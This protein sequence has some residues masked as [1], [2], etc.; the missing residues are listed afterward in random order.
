LTA[1]ILDL[2]KQDR[3]EF[4]DQITRL[5]D[6]I[7]VLKQENIELTVF[8][9]NAFQKQINAEQWLFELRQDQIND[10]NKIENLTMHSIHQSFQIRSLEEQ[11]KH[12]AHYI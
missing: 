7:A 5:R 6:D 8:S 3:D 9:K 12:D 10:E 1:R 11:T 2:Q 4:R